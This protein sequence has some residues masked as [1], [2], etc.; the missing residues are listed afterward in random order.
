MIKALVNVSPGLTI[1]PETGAFH[2]IF[3]ARHEQTALLVTRTTCRMA[4][5]TALRKNRL[6][7]RLEVNLFLRRQQAGRTQI[8]MAQDFAMASFIRRPFPEF[9]GEQHL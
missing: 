2:Q 5:Q 3:V 8:E 1:A 9:F 7:I 6:D 4:L